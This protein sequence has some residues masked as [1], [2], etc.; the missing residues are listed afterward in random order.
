[1]TAYIIDSGISSSFSQ[2]LQRRL[3]RSIS[4]DLKDEELIVTD[5]LQGAG[6]HGEIVTA[7]IDMFS[8]DGTELVSVKILNEHNSGMNVQL[9]SALQHIEAIG[10][11][12][13][14]NLSLGVL[15]EEFDNELYDIINKLKA[16]QIYCICSASKT[17]SLPM[18]YDNVITVSDAVMFNNDYDEIT[19]RI[20][21]I[22]DL[23]FYRLNFVPASATSFA[24]P[25]V[26]AKALE[27]FS[28][29]DKPDFSEIK[30]YL[31]NYFRQWRGK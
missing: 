24:S 13:I 18:I 10:N 21:Y 25:F 9:I 26:T 2:C 15:S 16:M 29:S 20:D 28:V 6:N 22:V 12:G 8:P 31:D 4:I 19:H 30:K 7:I 27:Y 3:V 11:K 1:M 14:I 5:S 17:P 23:S